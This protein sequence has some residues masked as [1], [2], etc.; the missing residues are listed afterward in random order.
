MEFIA[1][2]YT[3]L[4]NNEPVE[5]WIKNNQIKQAKFMEHKVTLNLNEETIKQIRDFPTKI[6]NG[7][8]LQEN[9]NFTQSMSNM[10]SQQL[11]VAIAKQDMKTLSRF[12][13]SDLVPEKSKEKFI[14]AI[15][16]P[17]G[18][19]AVLKKAILK[20]NSIFQNLAK[21]I[22]RFFD[23][24]I[25]KIAN[26]QLD[27]YLKEY[28]L[29]E[30]N[31][32]PPL[33][34]LDTTISLNPKLLQHAREFFVN[35]DIKSIG[36]EKTSDKL[37]QD[38]FIAAQIKHGFT[39]IE[40]KTALQIVSKSIQ[41]QELM[42]NQTTKIDELQSKVKN[43]QKKLEIQE[44]KEAGKNETIEDFKTLSKGVDAVASIDLLI[45]NKE[46][47]KMDDVQKQ[48]IEDE[49]IFKKEPLQERADELKNV[50]QIVEKAEPEIKTV[51][52]R[53]ATIDF[54]SKTIKDQV[55]EK[56]QELQKINRQEQAQNRDF[57]NISIV[58]FGQVSK[59]ALQNWQE[60][61][62]QNGADK[63]VTQ[64]FVDASLRNAAQ[65]QK[66]GILKEV[67][68]GEFKFKDQ[69]AK[70]VLYKNI[71]KT[72]EEIQEANK[73][74]KNE[75]EINPKEELKERVQQLA[76]EKSFEK[77]VTQDGSIDS[78]Q[79]HKF[80]DHLQKLSAQ[81]KTQ[82]KA[83]IVTKDDLQLAQNGQ[84]Q[85]QSHEQSRGA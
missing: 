42:S 45:E 30:F 25:D 3:V 69:F 38:K 19:R 41:V 71:N 65:L 59:K 60:K 81:L 39:T 74:V 70:E 31:K 29:K 51:Y 50:A 6:V 57:M 77:L 75:I 82:E 63:E 44:K 46:Y 68:P 26:P 35:N 15:N 14:E 18:L 4:M 12:A 37:L 34:E 61:A 53:N 54:N 2:K 24:Q 67:A 52:E 55:H 47:L 16:S 13:R 58:K 33:R 17:K 64:K 78:E 22:D 66:I 80:A 83:N 43:L 76:S 1:K 40:A 8:N 73:G 21:K 32:A 20:T 28:Q 62:V 5:I 7:A 27:N 9:K 48:A 49:L 85:A 11:D 23:R 56:W 84:K 36:D 10:M 79:L 72:T